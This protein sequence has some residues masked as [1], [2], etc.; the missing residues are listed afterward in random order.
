MFIT[1]ENYFAWS[2]GTKMAIALVPNLGFQLGFIM[3]WFKETDG[4][5]GM[6]WANVF[7][8]VVLSDNLTLGHVWLCHILFSL[9]CIVILWYID[10][11]R[12][13][14]FGVAQPLYFPF[15]VSFNNI[16]AMCCPK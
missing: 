1:P 9:I 10:N 12:P 2:V 13:G 15:T 3:T 14:K 11:V 8:P 16:N 7:K 6:T 5:E 4:S